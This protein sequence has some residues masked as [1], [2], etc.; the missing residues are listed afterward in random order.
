RLLASAPASLVVVGRAS[1]DGTTLGATA[2]IAVLTGLVFGVM[3]AAQVG[4]SELAV[5]LKAG[6]R[7]TRLRP[8]ATRAKRGIVIAEV[9]LAVTLLTAAGLLLH[10]FTKLLSVDPGFR[11]QGVL[12]MKVALPQRAY[13]STRIRAFVQSLEER[14]RAVPGASV[15][16]TASGIPLD[17]SSYGFTFKI[18]GRPV[19]RSSDEPSTEVRVVTPGFFDAIGIPVLSGRAVTADDRADAKRILVVNRA[20]A[21]KFFPNENPIGHAIELGWGEDPDGTTREVLGVVGDVHS[22]ALADAPEP[23]VYAPMS[24]TPFSSLSILVRTNGSPAA[25]TVPLRNIVHELDRDVPIYSVQ[26]MEERVASSVG[27]QRFY[28]TL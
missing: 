16:G 25:L 18:R 5:A 27:A 17:N 9:A 22:F 1:I 20:F 15:V 23:T 6:A 26:T 11:P 7:G 12:S 10:S 21:K 24:Q 8:A 3:P 14:A 4:R 28:A 2:L 19:V 13:D